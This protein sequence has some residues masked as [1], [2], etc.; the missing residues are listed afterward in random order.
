[1]ASELESDLQDIV[2]WGKMGL[3]NLSAGKTQ[4]VSFDW[5]KR[6]G[7]ID[8]KIDKSVFEEKTSFFFYEYDIRNK[9]T[10]NIK[11]NKLQTMQP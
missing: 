2:D 8:V 9:K 10:K 4:L 7:A 1:M 3:V 5:S 6:A 11:K